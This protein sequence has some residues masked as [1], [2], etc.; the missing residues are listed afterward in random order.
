MQI[1]KLFRFT[2]DVEAAIDVEKVEETDYGTNKYFKQFLNQLVNDP[3]A[4]RNFLLINFMDYYVKYDESGFSTLVDM[5]GKE[6]AYILSAAEKC[7]TEVRCYFNDLFTTG[8]KQ[9][10]ST[11]IKKEKSKIQL[12]PVERDLIMCQLISHLSVLIPI[13]FQWY[14]ITSGICSPGKNE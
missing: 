5:V 8:L 6:H 11:T 12:N 3:E 9:D 14:E 7:E 10:D 1:K 13:K 4:L 2:V